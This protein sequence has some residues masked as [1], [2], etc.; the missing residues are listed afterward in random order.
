MRAAAYLWSL[1][2][3]GWALSTDLRSHRIKNLTAAVGLVGGLVLHFPELRLSLIGCIL[4]LALFPL[5]CIRFM[6]AGDIKLLC[7]LG[8]LVCYPEIIPLILWSFVFCGLHILMRAVVK[9]GL[10][11]FCKGIWKDMVLSFWIRRPVSS[12]PAGARLP[13]AGSIAAAALLGAV[14]WMMKQ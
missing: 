5:F 7:A 11:P 12:F 2:I 1:L 3:A 10:G 14:R 13:M 9:N 4:P 6:G 8:A